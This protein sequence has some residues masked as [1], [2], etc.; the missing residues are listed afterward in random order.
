METRRQKRRGEDAQATP[1]TETPAKLLQP[2]RSV[3]G[4]AVLSMEQEQE[5]LSNRGARAGGGG[6]AA[7]AI[8]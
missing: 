6:G 5:E 1:P 4:A 3:R 2:P 7:P 8:G